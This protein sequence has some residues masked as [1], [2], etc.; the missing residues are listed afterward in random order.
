[1]KK[2]IQRLLIFIIGLP[3]VIVIV[4]FLPY[5]KHL[6][7]NILVILFSGL[8][9]LEFT[10]ILGKKGMAI[11]P[12]EALILGVLGPAVLTVTSSLGLEARLLPLVYTLGAFWLLVSR[13]FCS[14]E[15]LAA[16]TSRI[17][18]GF[19]V[20]LYPGLFMVWVVRM[21][22]FPGAGPV[23]LVFLLMVFCNDSAAWAAG[24]LFGKGSRGLVK[25]SPNKS[26]AGFIGGLIASILI[27]LGA[28]LWMGFTP[29]RLPCPLAGL[30]TGFCTGIAA[31]LGDLAESALKRSSGI[32][33][34][35]V[36]IPGRGGVLDT[37]DSIAL[38]APVFYMLY[39][40]FYTHG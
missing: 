6:A 14:T 25:A 10:V 40:F 2:L 32:K 24:S 7:V 27:G 8:G 9:A 23:I 26:L 19:S 17:A 34:S 16:Y 36:L 33:D 20:M 13:I 29:S 3:L 39:Q 4:L 1:M 31:S 30:L 38:A 15:Q 37:I 21:T 5:R 12:V 22:M 11:P 35:G 28:D 18:A